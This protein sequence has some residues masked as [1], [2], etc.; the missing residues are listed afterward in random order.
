MADGTAA[1]Y[2]HFSGAALALDAALQFG[3][4][5]SK[6]AMYEPP[7]N[8]DPAAR[9][10]WR[11]YLEQLTGALAAGRHGDAVAL[12]MAYVGTSAEQIDGMRQ[13]DFWP[14][15]AAVGPTL[16]YD[17]TPTR[18]T[19]AAGPAERASGPAVRA[20]ASDVRNGQLPV[21]GRDRPQA[22]ADDAARRAARPGGSGTRCQ[23]GRSRPG[24]AGVPDLT[25]TATAAGVQLVPF[26][27]GQAGNH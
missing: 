13:Q 1:L 21:H 24:A 5:V 20:R 23:P 14:A 4:S 18:G 8:D 27:P 19:A 12:F 10:A 3:D 6:I 9:Q 17:H 25:T 26:G 15:M 16:A 22:A 7:Y 11:R 2:G